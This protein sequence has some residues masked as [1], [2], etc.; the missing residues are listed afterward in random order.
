LVCGC[1]ESNQAKRIFEKRVDGAE[2]GE[3]LRRLRSLLSG[4]GRLS[5]V[6]IDSEEDML[7]AETHP[8]RFGS[9]M[10]AYRVIGWQE[11]E[12]M[13]L[14][15]AWQVCTAK[16]ASRRWSPGSGRVRRVLFRGPLQ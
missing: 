10:D 14:Y 1:F 16:R 3:M 5:S 6:L 7:S 11:G 12:S 4:H 9:L 13:K 15:L 8:R 2:P